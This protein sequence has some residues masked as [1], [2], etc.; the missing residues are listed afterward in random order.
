MNNN[1]TYINGLYQF[2]K[3]KACNKELMQS[4]TR[5]LCESCDHDRTTTTSVLGTL[6]RSDEISD[7]SSDTS[8]SSAFGSTMPV[9]EIASQAFRPNADEESGQAPIRY[10][11]VAGPSS[12]GPSSS[13]VT[14]SSSAHSSNFAV[15]V[16]K[17]SHAIKP[18]EKWKVCYVSLLLF[19]VRLVI[20]CIKSFDCNQLCGKNPKNMVANC[21]HC[22]CRQCMMEKQECGFCKQPIT[23]G[24]TIQM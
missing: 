11:A 4:Q 9:S 8:E 16:A 10:D 21:G 14:S 13:S 22:M 6:L 17:A 15:H 3:R 18:T 19:L 20:C 12:A 23:R 5:G 1:Y 24:Q 2:D 7:A